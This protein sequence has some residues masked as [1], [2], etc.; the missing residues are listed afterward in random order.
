MAQCIKG[1]S[2]YFSLLFV[3][4]SI[5]YSPLVCIFLGFPPNYKWE[6]EEQTQATGA[7]SFV[8]NLGPAWQPSER[9][10]DQS[11]AA[12]QGRT[13]LMSGTVNLRRLYA[14]TIFEITYFGAHLS[15]LTRA[16]LHKC[17]TFLFTVRFWDVCHKEVFLGQWRGKPVT[18]IS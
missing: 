2:F 13:D 17:L 8:V 5:F 10:R 9:Q 7:Q 14:S 3:F 12:S 6:I 18:G 15:N 16:F 1:D 11:G 4:F